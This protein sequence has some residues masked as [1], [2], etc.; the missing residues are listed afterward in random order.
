MVLSRLELKLDLMPATRFDLINVTKRVRQEYGEVL[1][2]YRKALYHSYPTTAGYFE[3]NL[4]E[5]LDHNRDTISR[6]VSLFPD[7]VPSPC[8][9]PA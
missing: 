7:P 6:V 3:Q 9:I 5:R 4:C 8:R 1:A 2:R